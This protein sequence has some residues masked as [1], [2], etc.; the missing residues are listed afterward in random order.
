MSDV[1][2]RLG[3]KSLLSR[4][5]VIGTAIWAAPAITLATAAPAL[6]ASGDTLNLTN[7]KSVAGSSNGGITSDIRTISFTVTAVSTHSSTGTVSITLTFPNPGLLNGYVYPTVAGWTLTSSTTN[8]ATYTASIAG[9]PS[10]TPITFSGQFKFRV[11]LSLL[12]AA[13]P[14]GTVSTA[15]TSTDNTT[16]NW[17][18]SLVQS[19]AL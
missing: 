18:G 11:L 7:L 15:G 2:S 8:S 1:E 10:G 4:R 9:T 17:T 5:K 6:A 16:P 13:W 3:E 12:P 14:S 19:A